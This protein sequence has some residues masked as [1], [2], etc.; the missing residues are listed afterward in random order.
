M[1]EKRL[2]LKDKASMRY[3]SWR[4]RLF[5]FLKTLDR[6]IECGKNAVIM[7]HVDLRLTDNAKLIIGDY[8]VIDSYA[9]LQLSKP[10][11]RIILEDYVTVGRGTFISAKKLVHIGKYS[12]IGPFCQINDQ[13]H[14]YAKGELIMNQLACIEP[15]RIGSDCWLGSGVRV[16]M[17]VTIGDGSVIGAGSIV[18]KSI[19]PYQIWAGNPARYIRDRD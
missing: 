13:S 4:R 2:L 8:C 5:T 14:S 1:V 12:M 16:L 7:P 15:V 10:E 9:M 11:P 17:G 19:P 3:I 6:R 18:T